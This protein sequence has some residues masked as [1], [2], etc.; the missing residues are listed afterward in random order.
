MRVRVFTI[1]AVGKKLEA[2]SRERD[3]EI[4]KL[5]KPFLTNHLFWVAASTPSGNADMMEGKWRSMINH[6]Q[7]IHEHEIPAYPACQHEPLEGENRDKEW[8]EPGI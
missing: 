3:C 6:V 1:T 5:W 2:L 8:F 7:D 4:V